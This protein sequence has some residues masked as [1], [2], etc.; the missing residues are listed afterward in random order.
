MTV[1][2]RIIIIGI[3]YFNPH[4]RK[5][6]DVSLGQ[7]RQIYVQISIHTPARGVTDAGLLGAVGVQISIHTPARG[8]TKE[9]QLFFPKK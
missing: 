9:S 8:V 3:A 2:C 1:C 5:G 6:S 4:S 7:Q